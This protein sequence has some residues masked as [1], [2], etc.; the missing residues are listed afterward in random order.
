MTSG[1]ASLGLV[2]THAH[3]MDPAF[4]ADRP[5]VVRRAHDAGVTALILVG[6]DLA[7]SRAAV[8]LA[9]ATPHAWAAVGIHPNSAAEASDADF[10]V[11]AELNGGPSRGTW[12]SPSASTCPSSSTT[13]WRTRTSW[14]SL[15]AVMCAASSTVSA[16]PTSTIWNACWMLDSGC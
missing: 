12:T 10:E 7:T 3:L 11:L 15:V 16:R 14:R 4:D 1:S 13:V 8:G 2:D 6:Y 9:R 5:S